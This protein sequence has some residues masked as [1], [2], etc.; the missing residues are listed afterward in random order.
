MKDVVH[1]YVEKILSISNKGPIVLRVPTIEEQQFSKK[2]FRYHDGVITITDVEILAGVINSLTIIEVEFT[3]KDDLYFSVDFK[4]GTIVKSLTLEN[5]GMSIS[6]EDGRLYN[7]KY[8][9]MNVNG[10]IVHFDY[11]MVAFIGLIIVIVLAILSN[12]FQ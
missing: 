5:N 8:N 3:L 4:A 12:L 1:L 7:I 6:L 9:R 11:L 10:F 2:K